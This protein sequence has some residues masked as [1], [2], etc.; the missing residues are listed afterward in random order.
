MHLLF[1]TSYNQKRVDKMYDDFIEVG[2]LIKILKFS[3]FG[4][5]M[6]GLIWSAEEVTGK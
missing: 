5:V 6:K 1:C 3:A 4:E 2:Y